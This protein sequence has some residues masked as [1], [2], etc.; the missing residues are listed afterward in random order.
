MVHFVCFA[1]WEQQPLKLSRM[2]SVG[3]LVWCVWSGVGC[4]AAGVGSASLPLTNGYERTQSHRS[5]RLARYLRAYFLLPSSHDAALP[6]LYFL[7]LYRT[8]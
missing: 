5:R 1:R 2:E 6:S 7:N 4:D 3:R 8:F